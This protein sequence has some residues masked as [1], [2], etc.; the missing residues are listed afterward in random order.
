MKRGRYE[1][2]ILIDPDAYHLNEEKHLIEKGIGELGLLK[3][4]D[5]AS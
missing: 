1:G 4:G 3:C 2:D 5:K